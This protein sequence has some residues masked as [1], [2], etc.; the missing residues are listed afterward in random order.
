MGLSKLD[1]VVAPD[2]S[3]QARDMRWPLHPNTGKRCVESGSWR[4]ALGFSEKRLADIVGRQV[5]NLP[6]S[7]SFNLRA[8]VPA[9]EL[10]QRDVAMAWVQ[11]RWFVALGVGAGCLALILTNFGRAS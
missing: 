7:L 9:T 3:L 5:L 2:H 11:M 8:V 1:H 6:Y 4:V 10:A